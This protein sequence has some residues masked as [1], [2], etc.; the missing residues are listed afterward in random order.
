MQT[1][2]S[3]CFDKRHEAVENELTFHYALPLRGGPRANRRIFTQ[4]LDPRDHHFAPDDM[5]NKSV[6][7][8]SVELVCIRMHL[9]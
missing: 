1:V 5:M 7:P 8:V 3:S 4:N 6:E 2:L 9:N